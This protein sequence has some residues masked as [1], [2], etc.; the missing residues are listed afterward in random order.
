MLLCCRWLGHKAVGYLHYCCWSVGCP[1]WHGD[2][3]S[4]SL[5]RRCGTS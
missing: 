3:Q 2:V 4:A 1:A 5:W